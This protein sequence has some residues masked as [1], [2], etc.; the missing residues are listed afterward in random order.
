MWTGQ[1]TLNILAVIGVVAFM[2]FLTARD[3]RPQTTQA[4]VAVDSE[5]T[6]TSASEAGEKA[7][8]SSVK[9]APAGFSQDRAI[10]LAGRHVPEDVQSFYFMIVD[11]ERDGAVQAGELAQMMLK[12]AREQDH[13]GVTGADAPLLHQVM[14]M[15]F[16]LTKDEKLGPLHVVYV[17]QPEHQ[18]SVEAQA[19]RAG[20]AMD[21]VAYR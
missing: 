18:A 15:A 3:D 11:A 6:A 9:T 14:L 2:A 1:L 20:L 16:A 8:A 17:G 13:L 5:I 21:F 10:D 7:L 19:T 4:A 12:A